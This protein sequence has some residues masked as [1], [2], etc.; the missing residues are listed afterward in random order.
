MAGAATGRDPG[1]QPER[2]QLAWQRTAV[3]A[4]GVCV[5]AA[6]TAVRTGIPVL[7][8]PASVLTCAAL[9][10]VRPRPRGHAQMRGRG[11]WAS[12][13]VTAGVVVAV[14]VVGFAL[15]AHRFAL[16]VAPG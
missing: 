9:I 2:T 12:L 1:L 11:V 4:P 14:A 10:A 3:A 6:V 15:A 5:V 16:L 8:I 13:V 7:V